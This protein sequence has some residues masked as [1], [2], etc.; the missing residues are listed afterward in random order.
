MKIAING[1][2]FPGIDNGAAGDRASEAELN[3]SVM[4]L[5][6]RGLKV[7]GH[8]VLKIQELGDEAIIR[9]SRGFKSD[10]FLSIHCNAS[11]NH[12]VC[13]T[14]THYF[15]GE[16]KRLAVCVQAQL[17]ESLKTVDRGIK[18]SENL[19]LLK[20]MD[21]PAIL[22]EMAFITN[23]ADEELLLCRKDDFAKAIAE[24]TAAYAAAEEIV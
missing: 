16:G 17:V 18:K 7:F 23:R 11:V 21:C 6:A 15:D 9:A 12:A 13:G 14:E 19:Y 24:G 3:Q 2:H 10:L 20:Y 4:L 8:E 22:I 1:G 5:A